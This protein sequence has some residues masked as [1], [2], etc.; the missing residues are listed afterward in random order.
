MTNLT[1]QVALRIITRNI[2]TFWQQRYVKKLKM[3]RVT[4]KLNRIYEWLIVI[5]YVCL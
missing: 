5:V 4:N 3:W 1:T 2:T